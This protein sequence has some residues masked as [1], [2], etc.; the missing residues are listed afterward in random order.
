V[1]RDF[2]AN[3]SHE[4]KTPLTAIKGYVE[5]LIDGAMDDARVSGQFLGKIHDNAERLCN[6]TNDL[7]TLARLEA[8]QGETG[9]RYSPD[10]RVQRVFKA[11]ED[12]AGKKSITFE[13][14]LGAASA[15]VDGDAD[16]FEQAVLNLMDNAINY[17]PSGGKVR[18]ITSAGSAGY[19]VSV[20]DTGIGIPESE[21]HRIFERFYRVDKARSRDAGGTGLG[22]AIVRHVALMHRGTI[23]L[24]SRTGE[25]STFTLTLPLSQ[26]G[27]TPNDSARSSAVD[28]LA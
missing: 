21:Q 19:S 25:G 2:V 10:D 12:K 24:Q 8:E 5:T 6:L 26:Q 4:L 9:E 23:T 17:T 18:V 28:A 11:L 3:V 13:L 20:A 1:R 14:Q 16:S 27:G 7:L 22:L 15:R